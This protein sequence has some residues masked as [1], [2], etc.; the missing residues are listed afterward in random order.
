MLKVRMLPERGWNCATKTSTDALGDQF[1]S[2]SLVF[3][4]VNMLVQCRISYDVQ[5]SQ[6]PA[7][8]N[9]VV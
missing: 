5:V 6:S 3:F 8:K 2:T 1:A 9:I 4:D 7:T